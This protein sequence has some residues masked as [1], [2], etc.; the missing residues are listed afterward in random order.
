MDTK[1]GAWIG[2]F[3]AA[4]VLSLC[5][6]YGAQPAY[7]TNANELKAGTY[8]NLYGTDDTVIYT[9]WKT[10]QRDSL[11]KWGVLAVGTVDF[12]FKAIVQIAGQAGDTITL[13]SANATGGTE[14]Y[15][16]TVN[17]DSLMDMGWKQWSDYSSDARDAV[18]STPGLIK[19]RLAI[20]TYG[21]TGTPW[22]VI[23]RFTE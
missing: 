7:S 3:F 1:I 4:F 5:L 11:Y 8:V 23:Y 14:M 19:Y 16:N 10:V 21:C 18:K 15:V 13:D 9:D 6:W 12:A 17:G 20:T 2:G 22:F